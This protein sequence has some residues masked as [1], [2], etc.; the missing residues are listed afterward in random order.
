MP[1]TFSCRSRRCMRMLPL[2]SSDPL[3]TRSYAR[4]G[5]DARSS[6]S[7]IPSHPGAGAVNGWCAESH[8][9]ASSSQSNS[10]NSVTNAKERVSG[11]ASS[12]CPARCDRIAANHWFASRAGPAISVIRSPRCAPARSANRRTHSAGIRRPGESNASSS[13]N[14]SSVPSPVSLTWLIPAAPNSLAVSSIRRMS[15]PER[16]PIPGTAIAFMIPPRSSTPWNT[17][18]SVSAARSLTSAISKP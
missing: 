14:E 11:S 5:M 3:Q 9:P 16:L 8:R 13:V 10:G 7:S 6:P 2:A 1:K 18:N 17:R 15:E 12:S 4:D